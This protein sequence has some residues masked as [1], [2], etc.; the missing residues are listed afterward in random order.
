MGHDIRLDDAL[1][2]Y[3]RA[4][5]EDEPELY[6]RLRAETDALGAISVMQIGWIQARFMQAILQMTGARVYVEIGV[7]TGYSSLAM[8]D[9]LPDDGRIIALDISDEW[10]AMGQ[11]YWDEAGVADK[12]DLRIGDA[13]AAMDNLINSDLKGRVDVVFIDADK[14]GMEHYLTQAHTLLRGGGVVLADNVLWSGDVINTADTSA[15]T[16][17]I[18]AFN[19]ALKNDSRFHVSMVPV[20]DGITIAVKR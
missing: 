15:N 19:T 17:A 11:K 8:A 14:G 9:A 3:V 2:S 18:R 1:E 20:G 13:S 6:K 12:I 16:R 5:L 10:P 7:F 4:S